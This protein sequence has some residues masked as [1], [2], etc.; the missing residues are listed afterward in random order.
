MP[1]ETNNI[2]Q[3]LRSDVVQEIVTRVPPFLL[4]YGSVAILIFI[5]VALGL[6]YFIKYPDIIIA[7]AVVT[8]VNA[9]QQEIAQVS[10]RID[11]LA[12]ADNSQ[13]KKGDMI[14]LLQHN[15]R[16]QDVLFLEK[17]LDT[18]D[19]NDKKLQYPIYDL[20][21]LLIGDLESDY[22]AFETAYLNFDL[23]RNLRPLDNDASAQEFTRRELQIQLENTLSRKRNNQKE[24]ELKR[25]ELNRMQRLFDKG[26]IARQELE[27]K[28]LD[29][30]Q[31]E[32]NYKSFEAQISQLRN[33]LSN[34][35]GTLRSL[36]IENET[37]NFSLRRQVNQAY[38]NLKRALNNYKNTYLITAREDGRIYYSNNWDEGNFVQAG[39]LLFTIFP[40]NPDGYQALCKAPALNAGKL[41]EGQKVRLDIANFPEAEYGSIMG[42]LS[43]IDT[44]PDEDGNYTVKVALPDDLVTTY[45]RSIDISQESLA[46]ANIITQDL[47]LLDRFTIK[48]REIF[49]R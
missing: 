30:I 1:Q 27:F 40:E 15:A 33:Q 9:Q 36:D 18:L 11:S 45:K 47:R 24:L 42:T 48:F 34:T 8:T 17:L 7:P 29:V 49:D 22:A 28:Q 21:V 2:N 20:P 14:L 43:S 25:A 13:V 5:V 31:Y 39:D 10:T 12:I 26:V 6:S 46:T 16:F 38:V 32:R 44:R 23:N 35:A 41:Q 3:E 19:I 4:R 37:N